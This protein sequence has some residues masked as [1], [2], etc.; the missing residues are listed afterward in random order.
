[1]KFLINLCAQDG[2]VSHNSGV[3]TMV[4]RYI[5]CFIKYFNKGVISYDVNLF[6]PEYNSWGFGFSLETKQF[7]ESLEHFKIYQFSNGTEGKKFFGARENW[8]ELCK[9]AAEV[10]N[11]QNME[12]YDYV[13]TIANDTPFGGLLWTTKEAPNH[14]KV[15]IPHSTAKIHQTEDVIKQNEDVMKRVEWEEKIVDYVNTHDRAYIGMVGL[16]IKNHI[17]EE[18][19]LNK[20]KAIDY[21][22]GEVLSSKTVYVEDE[23][24][25]RLFGELDKNQD[26]LLSFGRPEHYKNLDASI[27]VADALKIKSIIITSEY[28]PDM[29][30]VNYLKE[31]AKDKD[32]KLFVNVPFN[33]PQYIINHYPKN[34]IL[35]V[36][37]KKEIAGLVINEIRK[38]NKPNILLVSNDIDGL[39][40]QV[41]DGKDAVLVDLEDIEGSAKKI[42]EHFNSETIKQI[43]KGALERLKRDYDFEKN[44]KNFFER[45]LKE[46]KI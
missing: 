46:N 31:L 44:T 24:C 17:I 5:E 6:T 29:P 43:N 26:I 40:E 23:E 14:I 35:L 41:E 28:F 3:G 10:V 9:N 16:F 12:D 25:E 27:K 33:F 7:N 37:S 19:G 11:K 13:F 22:N 45:L 34:I 18:Y 38:F 15:F 36:P 30:Y 39:N 8:I 32:C 4:K 20:N 2:V 42:K 21:Y 1:M